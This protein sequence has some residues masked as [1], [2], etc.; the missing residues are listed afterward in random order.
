M[1]VPR[2]V[3]SWTA[4]IALDDIIGYLV[5]AIETPETAGR[6]FDVGG[7]EVLRYGD[8][9]TTYG[10]VTGRRTWLIHVPVLT[11]RL[12]SYWLGLV[13]SVPAEIARPLVD[14]LKEDLVPRNRDITSLIPR[15][16]KT[17]REAVETALDAERSEPLPA[18]W[19]EGALRFR[20]FQQDV[21]YYSKGEET[22]TPANVP[23][24]VLWDTVRRVGG[25]RGWYWGDWLWSL[26]GLMD[27]AIGGPGM[28]RGRR[29]PTDVRVGDA[30]DFWRV[31]AVQPG[32]R[33][34]LVAEMKLPGEAV[35]EFAVEARG[36]TE[37]VLWTTARFHPRGIPG[38]LYWYA[39]TPL[40]RQ[41]FT[42]MPG[43]MVREAERR[44][45]RE[46]D[47]KRPRF[48]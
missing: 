1:I 23:V 20:G 21:S 44:G 38:L 9:L 34:T 12:S 47:A 31:A 5:G 45:K 6:T 7:P 48:V 19:Q 8:L 22:Q 3:R 39:V 13:T 41:I 18:R 11:P 17:Y 40:H 36:E 16:L 28:R 4:P 15:E 10:A 27:R 35:L 33:L 46:K 2:W 24:D 25:R 43:A 14:G 30:L 29:H 26:R 37:S 32:E 42:R